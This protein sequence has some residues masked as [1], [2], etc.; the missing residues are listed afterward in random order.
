MKGID[1][2]FSEYYEVL[3]VVAENHA[4]G[5]VFTQ[6]NSVSTEQKF[7]LV[8]S[9]AFYIFS[10]YQNILVCIRFNDNMKKIHNYLEKFKNYI[11]YS[12]ETMNHF[13]IYSQNLNTYSNFNANAKYNIEIL[14]EYLTKLNKITKYSLSFNKIGEIGFVLKCFYDLYCDQ[15]YHDAL[16]Y[17]F[18]FNGYIENL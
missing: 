10:I 16:M 15:K 4:L 6:F 18:G 17:A 7:Y 1:L 3:K 8:I 11:S 2:N 12:L 14:N 9:A 5:K 13:L